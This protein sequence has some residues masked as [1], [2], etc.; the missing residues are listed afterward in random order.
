MKKIV[1]LFLLIQCG[2]SVHAANRPYDLIVAKDGSG[3]YAS[4]Q[5]A[6]N[7][8]PDYRKAGPTRIY[9]KKGTYKEKIV[10]SASKECVQLIG[11]DGVILTYDDYAS[12]TNI[13]GENKGTS[14]SASIYIFGPD[15]MAE[16]ITFENS[17]GPVGQAVACHVAG[18]R[19]VFRKC[20]FLGFQD[21]L[22]TFGENTREYYEDCYI[23]GTV[24]FIFGKATCVFN[25][26][27][28]RSKRSGGFLTA[29]ATPQG[30]KYGYVFYDCKLTA[31]KGVEDG[32]VCLSRPWRPYAKTIFI[33]CE[34][35]RH[36]KPEG[37]NNW[38]KTE[39]EHTAY[40][41]EYKSKGAGANP[42]L[43]AKWSHQL[44][45]INGYNIHDV[46]KGSDN[47]DPTVPFYMPQIT[48]PVIPNQEVYLSD[49][50]AVGDGKT[51]CTDA[52]AKAFDALTANGGGRLVVPQGVWYTGPITLRSHTE[53]HLEVGAVILFSDSLALYPV[54]TTTYEGGTRQKCQSPISAFKQTDIAITGYG[55]ID[56]CGNSWR[57]LK[58]AKVTDGQWKKM[59]SK[60]GTFV[61]ENLWEP[62]DNR[63]N[64]RP[65]M[66]DL[67][68][69]KNILVKDI[70][71]QNPPAWNL[72]PLMC[73]NITIDHVTLRSPAY[74]QNGD[75]LDLESCRNAL[76]LNS[77]FDAGDDCI[78]LKS[79]K[80]EEGRK[81]GMPTENIIV[82]GC[83]VYNGHG[84]FVVGSEM[85]GGVRNVLVQDCQFVGTGNGLRFKSCRGRGGVVEN[86]YIRGISMANIE[87]AA[88]TF[89]MYYGKHDPNE[90][91]PPVDETTPIFRKIE[92]NDVSCRG[93]KEGLHFRGLPEM[94]IQDVHLSNINIIADSNPQF[95]YCKNVWIY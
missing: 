61:N 49:F 51:L 55:I 25:R 60:S 74:G 27:E 92:I 23:E 15:F 31:D 64:M 75:A 47:W 9:I 4:V 11:E 52:F 59:T 13:F 18:D 83:T 88:V 24:D 35:G 68:E 26:C 6:V 84:G 3:Q 46:L 16:N 40:Y 67:V 58:R 17:S 5:E 28:L 21:T 42:D 73:E 7:A 2:L 19:A 65:V 36:I 89:D 45:S 90:V 62:A 78:C 44:S 8:V 77:T 93:A 41:A 70:V 30:C 50:G 20:R 54:I 56:G 72:H 37:W 39:N 79:G 91:V 94:P 63:S 12:K 22:Y 69:C 32:S 29:P 76:V 38:G 53:L 80:D 14:G 66:V 34:M 87:D 1:L 85:S 10:I 57:P 81:R 48:K 86:I 71:I 43:R 95:E 33:R 82:K